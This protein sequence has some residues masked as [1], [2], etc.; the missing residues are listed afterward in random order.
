MIDRWLPPEVRRRRLIV[1]LA[2][3]LVAFVLLCVRASLD[4]HDPRGEQASPAARAAVMK[5]ATRWAEQVMSYTAA[6]A[7]PDIAAAKDLMTDQMRAEY[8]QTLPPADD[9]KDQAAKGVKVSA[10][11]TRLDDGRASGRCPATACAVGLMS[12]RDDRASVLLFVNQYATAK[13]TKET[14]VN[15]TWQ[16]LRLVRQDGQWLIAG[17]EGP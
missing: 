12:L 15:P 13:S 2:V 8:E 7:E 9:R 1:A 14:V 5:Q 11:V 16:I 3:T 10:R 17:M 6:T 4:D